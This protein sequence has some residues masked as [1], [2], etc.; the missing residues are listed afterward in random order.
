MDIRY[1]R[2]EP[3]R[4]GD[5]PTYVEAGIVDAL[6]IVERVIDWYH[7]EEPLEGPPKIANQVAVVSRENKDPSSTPDPSVSDMHRDVE[8][9]ELDLSWLHGIGRLNH[10]VEGDY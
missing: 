9:M 8:I 1:T 6:R 7:D 3:V 4:P 10:H 5:P 2:I